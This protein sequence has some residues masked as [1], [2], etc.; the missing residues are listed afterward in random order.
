MKQIL[1]LGITIAV[2]VGGGAVGH[3]TDIPRLVIVIGVGLAAVG[4][5]EHLT[6]NIIGVA[7]GG[8]AADGSDVAYV[9]IAVVIAVEAGTIAFGV[10]HGAH[11]HGGA[12]GAGTGQEAI[13][14]G[15]EVGTAQLQGSSREPLQSVIT[16]GIAAVGGQAHTRQAAVAAVIGVAIGPG[17]SEAAVPGRADPVIHRGEP[18]GPIKGRAVELH[19]I[20]PG[21]LGHGGQAAK[22]VIVIH[23]VPVGG[24]IIH[25][26]YGAVVGVR[27]ADGRIEYIIIIVYIR[28]SFKLIVVIGDGFAGAVVQ[29]NHTAIA[30][31]VGVAG[32]IPVSYVDR[33]YLAEAVIAHGVGLD[34]I[35]IQTG[36]IGSTLHGA[37]PAIVISINDKRRIA[38]A[39]ILNTTVGC[40]VGTIGLNL[41]GISHNGGLAGLFADVVVIGVGNGLT[42]GIGLGG[43]QVAV[44]VIGGRGADLAAGTGAGKG[45]AGGVALSVIGGGHAQPVIGG[46]GDVMF[47]VIL[48]G[49]GAIALGHL[50]DEVCAAVREG[51]GLILGGSDGD[52]FAVRVIFIALGFLT[53][54]GNIR[55]A[56]GV[57]VAAEGEVHA[58][59][60]YRQFRVLGNDRK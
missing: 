9:V 30:G 59:G 3:G 7:G 15:E 13:A 40:I 38:N 11:H 45:G 33:A 56:G 29:L 16:I 21:V 46:L 14:A 22:S 28:Y 17:V 5:G 12:I 35:R 36:Y 27:V 4:L 1:P 34:H 44:G 39:Y 47:G 57:G 24:V 60:V 54:K 2:A 23:M 37:D 32:Q 25:P 6:Q 20:G 31:I 19:P 50:T 10:A 18:V 43:E 41:L 8:A 42:P 26:A 48:I 53:G 55:K 49:Q 51:L 58:D 52:Q